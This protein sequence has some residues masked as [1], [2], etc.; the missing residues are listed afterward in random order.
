MRRMPT[1]SQSKAYGPGNIGKRTAEYLYLLTRS[2]TE[3]ASK[4]IP[5]DPHI[6]PSHAHEVRPQL[7]ELASKGRISKKKCKDIDWDAQT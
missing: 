5:Q 3:D 6:T 1:S 2:T 7:P 4:T